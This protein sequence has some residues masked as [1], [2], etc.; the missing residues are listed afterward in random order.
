MSLVWTRK[1]IS[2]AVGKSRVSVAN[3]LRLLGL[4]DPV[5]NSVAEGNLSEGH[6]RALLAL[7]IPKEIE[8][9]A[10]KIAKRGLSVRATESLVKRITNRMS[11]PLPE[12]VQ[13]D[14]NLV[15]LESRLSIQ[16]GTKVRIMPG[17]NEKMRGFI[18][19]EYYGLDD[20]NRISGEIL[21]E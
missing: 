2:A 17:R 21:G 11:S 1:S 13:Q 8:L 7:T 15:D 14:P 12:P 6:A 16:L 4:P 20:L 18:S 3:S 10:V 19:V 5:Q 9:V